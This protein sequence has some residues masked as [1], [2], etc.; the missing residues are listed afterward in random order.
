MKQYHIDIE[1]REHMNN[2]TERLMINDSFDYYVG[3]I[4][5]MIFILVIRKKAKQFWKKREEIRAAN[6][7]TAKWKVLK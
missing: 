2:E 1:D 5:I 7:L 3:L 6:R 4:I